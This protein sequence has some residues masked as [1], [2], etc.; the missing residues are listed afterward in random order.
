MHKP[1]NKGCIT[2]ISDPGF[3]FVQPQVELPQQLKNVIMPMFVFSLS[4]QLQL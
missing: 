3:G 1:P 4:Q 2:T